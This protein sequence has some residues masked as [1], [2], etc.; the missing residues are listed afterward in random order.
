MHHQRLGNA[1]GVAAPGAVALGAYLMLALAAVTAGASTRAAASAAAVD[2]VA[3]QPMATPRLVVAIAVDQFSADLFDEYRPLFKAGLKRLQ[4]GIVFSEGLQSHAATETCPGH[5]TLLTGSHPSRTGIIANE[6][7]DESVARADKKVY[8]AED[9]S[10]AGSSS[11]NTTASAQFLKVPTL[12]DRMKAVEPRSRVVA[13]A[14]KDRAALMMGGHA[15]DSVW[16]WNGKHYVTL[17]D[18]ERPTPAVVTRVNADVTRTLA[19]VDTPVLDEPC[20]SRAHG[21][22]VAGKTVGALAARAAGDFPGF[23]TTRAFDRATTDIAIGLLRELDLG[24]GAVPDL[25]AISLSATDYVGHTFGTQ[26]AEMCEQLLGVDAEVGRILA[27]LD[28]AH[29]PYVVVLTADHGGIDLPERAR[30]EGIADAARVDPKLMPEAMSHELAVE[31]HLPEPVLLGTSPAGDIY[32]SHTIPQDLRARVAAA[33]LA[34]YGSHPQVAAVFTAQ[35]LRRLPAPAGSPAEWTLAERFK[36]SFDPERSGDLLV[37]LKPDVS[38]IPDGRGYVTTHGSPW[39]YDRRVP[40]LFFAPGLAG[41]EQPLS[42]ET[43]DIMPT[44]AALIGL[45]VP[46]AEIDGRCIDLGAGMSCPSPGG[47]R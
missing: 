47:G 11:T 14:G 9:P 22:A 26:G 38:P 4:T 12:G 27:A 31:F 29:H 16:F 45:A 30:R 41:F 42:I 1:P 5:S 17:A 37:A 20:R 2:G 46:A 13:V 32:L 43:V 39:N 25:L 8:C 23:R 36:A 21:V 7:F 3:R 24:G 19:E 6:W 33:A 18:R 40:I 34:R 15:I 28:A 10:V 44:L 35:E